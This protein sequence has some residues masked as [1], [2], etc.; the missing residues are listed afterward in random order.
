MPTCLSWSVYQAQITRAPVIRSNSCIAGIPILGGNLIRNLEYNVRVCKVV[1]FSNSRNGCYIK[2]A[3]YSVFI[4]SDDKNILKC[5]E[6]KLIYSPKSNYFS[7]HEE[8][9]IITEDKAKFDLSTSAAG[10]LAE[11]TTAQFFNICNWTNSM[12][13]SV[14]SK[15]RNGN[16]FLNSFPDPN[17]LSEFFTFT[18][19]DSERSTETNGG[20]CDSKAQINTN[21][22]SVDGR[23]GEI[24]SSDRNG[25]QFDC[26]NEPTDSQVRMSCEFEKIFVRNTRLL[27]TW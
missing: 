25:S 19:N 23:T 5:S 14:V 17:S 10:K 2:S 9:P 27:G 22:C 6:K 8:T 15:M 4:P 13:S 21:N 12:V 16:S 24:D 1:I 18:K 7:I 20:K 3:S 11:E 26:E